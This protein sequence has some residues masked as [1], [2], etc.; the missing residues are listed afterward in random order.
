MTSI[1][2][3]FASSASTAS[4]QAGSG[5]AERVARLAFRVLLAAA[6]FLR[7]AVGTKAGSS[8]EEAEER[9]STGDGSEEVE[10][11][12]VADEV[13]QDGAML[14][15]ERLRLG[16]VG[17]CNPGRVGELRAESGVSLP[18]LVLSALDGELA[19]SSESSREAG[20][21]GVIGIRAK[22]SSGAMQVGCWNC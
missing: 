18:E 5:A 1:W 9:E 2:S 8:W 20:E 15:V 3:L 21:M 13:I 17:I 7:E 22:R 6:D 19:R 10:E 11:L 14:E 16:T 4:T 12:A